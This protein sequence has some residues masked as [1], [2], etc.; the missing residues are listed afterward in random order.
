MFYMSLTLL[1]FPEFQI[2]TT[3]FVLSGHTELDLLD[4]DDVVFITSF[5]VVVHYL[6]TLMLS[7]K[8]LMLL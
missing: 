8:L 7:L 2:K 6:V 1:L 5:M 4:V 3:V